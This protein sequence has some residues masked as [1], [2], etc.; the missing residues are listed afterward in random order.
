MQSNVNNRILFKKDKA[1]AIYKACCPGGNFDFSKLIPSP[2][3]KASAMD[4][5]ERLR[6]RIEWNIEN[7]GTTVPAFDQ[8][9]G[10]IDNRM[11]YIQFKTKHNV[12]YPVIARFAHR[13]KVPFVHHYI[14]EGFIFWGMDVWGKTTQTGDLVIRVQI[15][16][17]L[18][19]DKR[20]LCI[21]LLGYDPEVSEQG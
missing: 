18:M 8:A 7:W 12:P 10:L 1:E 17:D 9:V 5:D 20:Q 21:D 15:E 16:R 4:E 2:Y 11:A 14:H 19:R 13:F 3:P 6:A